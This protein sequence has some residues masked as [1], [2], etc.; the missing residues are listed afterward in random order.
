MLVADFFVVQDK[1]FRSRNHPRT[2]K[3]RGQ[4]CDGK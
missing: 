2:L 3:D 1:V 4:T